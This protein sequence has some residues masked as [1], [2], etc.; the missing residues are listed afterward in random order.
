MKI[1][2][3]YILYTVSIE[4]EVVGLKLKRLANLIVAVVCPLFVD[5]IC[6]ICTS[7]PW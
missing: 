2:Y 4:S 6:S 3:L 1:I 5:V 7:C